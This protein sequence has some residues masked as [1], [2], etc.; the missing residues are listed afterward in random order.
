MLGLIKAS[1]CRLSFGI[2]LHL[3]EAKAFAAARFTIGNY[4]SAFHG[5]ILREKL[6]QV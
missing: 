6:F 3:D 4:L 5:T 2:A 1:D